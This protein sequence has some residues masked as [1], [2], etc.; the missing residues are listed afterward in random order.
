M[1]ALKATQEF[2]EQWFNNE[3]T[4][5]IVSHNAL[6]DNR[7]S[8]ASIQ[9]IFKHNFSPSTIND[10][11]VVVEELQFEVTRHREGG[12]IAFQHLWY[13]YDLQGNRT[14]QGHA[15]VESLA[16][17]STRGSV[18]TLASISSR[19]AE[20][21][22]YYAEGDGELVDDSNDPIQWLKEQALRSDLHPPPI[23]AH[24]LS[25]Y[26]GEDAI[27]EDDSSVGV[28]GVRIHL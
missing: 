14:L 24:A 17:I 9:A 16:S 18:R 26:A 12:D 5:P 8:L 13:L 7:K 6:P 3:D 20:C 28:G 21:S 11:I 25:D 2:I 10:A 1:T 27:S 22:F 19:I 15:S 4:T 23:G